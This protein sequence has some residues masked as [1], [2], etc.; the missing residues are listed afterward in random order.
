MN[1][2]R[3]INCSGISPGDNILW[4]VFIAETFVQYSDFGGF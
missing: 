4:Q 1:V 3:M 2:F